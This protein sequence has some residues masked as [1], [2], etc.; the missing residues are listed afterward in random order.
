MVIGQVWINANPELR[1]HLRKTSEARAAAFY[2]AWRTVTA[3]LRSLAELLRRARLQRQ[4]YGALSR[5]GDHALSDIGLSRSEIGSVSKAIA[6]EPLEAGMTIADLRRVRS[7]VS[8]G[9][10]TPVAPLPR[11]VERRSR[12]IPQPATAPVNQD[13]VAA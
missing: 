9:N 10:E 11:I 1:T 13:R 4:T 7:G 3:P 6:A 8:T 12:G 5:L 2:S